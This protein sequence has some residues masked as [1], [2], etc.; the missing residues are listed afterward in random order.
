[1]EEIGV[2]LA[3][4]KIMLTLWLTSGNLNISKVLRHLTISGASLSDWRLDDSNQFIISIE[5]NKLLYQMYEFFYY[6][7]R[8]FMESTSGIHCHGGKGGKKQ[9]KPRKML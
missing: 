8:M 4:V 9:D 1:M 7:K 3:P 6:F 2:R 5:N